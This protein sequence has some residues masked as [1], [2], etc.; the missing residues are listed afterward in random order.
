MQNT[1]LL[2]PLSLP[3]MPPTTLALTPY[4]VGVFSV[5]VTMLVYTVLA[6][7]VLVSCSPI[8]SPTPSALPAEGLRSGDWGDGGEVLVTVVER[9]SWVCL[10]I[11]CMFEIVAVSCNRVDDDETIDEVFFSLPRLFRT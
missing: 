3:P 8:P 11:G 6:Y 10:S 1:L 7:M 4:G 9:R 5:G 2:S